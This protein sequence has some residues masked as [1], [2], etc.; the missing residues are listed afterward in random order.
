MPSTQ[1][2][3]RKRGQAVFED[4]YSISDCSCSTIHWF[5]VYSAAGE[6]QKI[7]RSSDAMTSATMA[8]SSSETLCFQ[9]DFPAASTGPMSATADATFVFDATQN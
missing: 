5:S 1:A 6:R 9:V 7:F 3:S 8:A 4:L 2:M